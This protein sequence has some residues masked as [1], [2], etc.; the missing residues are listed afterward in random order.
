LNATFVTSAGTDEEG[1]ELLKMLGM[2][3]RK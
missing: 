3:F 2:P 1:F